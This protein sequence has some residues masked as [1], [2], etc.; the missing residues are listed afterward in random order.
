LAG[1]IRPGQFF[2]NSTWIGGLAWQANNFRLAWPGL[3]P[4][5][6]IDWTDQARLNLQKFILDG[7]L[8]GGRPGRQLLHEPRTDTL[9]SIKIYVLFKKIQRAKNEIIEQP[10]F[11]DALEKLQEELFLIIVEGTV[12]LIGFE[13]QEIPSI[14]RVSSKVVQLFQHYLLDLP[15]EY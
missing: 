2:K 15:T 14:V 13:Q 5:Q 11:D 7:G 9:R 6:D 10:I 1:Q 8:A 4:C 3:A 12:Y